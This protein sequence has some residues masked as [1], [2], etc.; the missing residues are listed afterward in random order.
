[1]GANLSKW[2][3][4]EVDDPELGSIGAEEALASGSRS[5]T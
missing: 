5:Q 3:S 2:Y 1:M 4:F